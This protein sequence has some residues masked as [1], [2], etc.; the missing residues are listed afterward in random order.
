MQF[1]RRLRKRAGLPA[2]L[3]PLVDDRTGCSRPNYVLLPDL[4]LEVSA[5]MSLEELQAMTGAQLH[6]DGPVVDLVVPEL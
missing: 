1:P 3:P 2:Q 6:V 4:S 5:E